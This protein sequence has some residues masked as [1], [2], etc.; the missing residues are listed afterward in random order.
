[1]YR[2]FLLKLCILQQLLEL[3]RNIKYDIV[4]SEMSQTV[5]KPLTS[6]YSL[7]IF[8]IEKRPYSIL[9]GSLSTN[10]KAIDSPEQ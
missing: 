5:F 3:T 10:S 7:I 4:F 8:G 2:I 6:H 1:M 9:N